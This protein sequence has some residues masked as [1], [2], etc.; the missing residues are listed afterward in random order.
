MNKQ[1]ATFDDFFSACYLKHQR[2]IKNYIAIRICNSYEA[3]DLA[4]DVFVR[5]W[6]YRAF[7]NKE[8]V[9]SL[10]FTI[11]RNI[12]T[13]KIRRY[14]KQEDFVAYLYNNVK[15]ESRSTT[16]ET[17]QYGE[18]KEMH[19][20]VVEK[21]PPKRRQIYELSF[22]Q[23]LS[24]PAIAGKLS[25]SPRTVECQLLLARK[26]VRTYLQNEYSKVG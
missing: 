5:L 6:E 2:Y 24:C 8:T 21:L 17:V 13:D 7:V 14:Y 11:A 4:Q 1:P 16:E 3:E 26:T 12:V 10:L 18:L 23:E 20:S 15:E 9:W 19:R 25:L 22:N